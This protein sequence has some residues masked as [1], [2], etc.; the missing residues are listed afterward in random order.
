MDSFEVLMEELTLI[1]ELNRI[2]ITQSLAVH[3]GKC[4]VQAFE[5]A[6][7]LAHLMG[8]QFNPLTVAVFKHG[9]WVEIWGA[10]RA[11]FAQITGCK[12]EV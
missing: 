5:R 6:I 1:E 3:T 10:F 9:G 4:T 8:H 12:L 11:D 2:V 7:Q